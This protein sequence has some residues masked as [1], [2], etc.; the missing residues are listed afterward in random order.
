[1]LLGTPDDT[2]VGRIN[3]LGTLN[4][5]VNTMDELTNLDETEVGKFAYAASQGRGKEKAQ[6][7]INAN[8]KNEIT[9]RN[10]TLSSSNA[11]FYQKLMSLKNAPDGELMRIIEFTIDYQGV[12]VIS[13][14][15]GKQMFE[16]PAKPEL[17]ACN[18]TVYSIHYGE[19]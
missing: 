5:I 3:K 18:R 12:D 8:R 17:W 4:N 9:W 13:T 16:P 2:A 11:S 15:E 10:I 6:M 7:H 19:P 1:M 14:A